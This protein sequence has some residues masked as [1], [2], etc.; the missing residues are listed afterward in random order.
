V[1]DQDDDDGLVVLLQEQ[2]P[3]ELFESVRQAVARCPMHALHAT[4]TSKAREV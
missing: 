4:E 1:F 2:P 3:P